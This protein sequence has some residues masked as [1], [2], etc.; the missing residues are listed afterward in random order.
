MN[1]RL[2]SGVRSAAAAIVALASVGARGG[3]AE[4][5][6]PASDGRIAWRNAYGVRFEAGAASFDRGAAGSPHRF[7]AGGA[8][9]VFRTSETGL[10][11]IVAYPDAVAERG[12][13]Q[14]LS[15]GFVRVDGVRAAVFDRPAP[16]GGTV[17]FAIPVPPGAGPREVEIVFPLADPVR[18]PGLRGGVLAPAAPAAPRR[19][20]YVAYGDS[21]TQGFWCTDPDAAYP[22]LVGARS[23]WEAVNLG[24]SG[25]V[26]T[27]EDGAEIVR[28]APDLATVMIGINDCLQ[29]VPPD[30]FR[31]NYAGLLDAIR[32]AAPRL[33]L[34]L[35]TPLAVLPGGRWKAERA[36]D[37]RRA[38]EEIVAARGDPHLR[39]L[40]GPDLLPAERRYFKDGLHPNDAGFTVLAERL[41]RALAESAPSPRP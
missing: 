8:R 41:A 3:G 7:D 28:A 21:I 27:P 32:R 1:P 29:N 31:A 39:V 22:S 5:T 14:Y 24:F 16:A 34:T 26:T 40:R 37:Y 20:R 30:R 12:K 17:E 23:G 11:A 33:P 38:I 13:R 10:W 35:V 4:A 2:S 6:I 19:T 9:A 25:R 15:R 18:W 36:D